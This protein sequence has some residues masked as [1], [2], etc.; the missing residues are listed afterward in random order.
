ME[1]CLWPSAVAP[2][3]SQSTEKVGIVHKWKNYHKGKS[4]L[5]RLTEITSFFTSKNQYFILFSRIRLFLSFSLLQTTK[6]NLKWPTTLQQ[7]WTNW[8]APTL[9][10]FVNAKT[11]LDKFLGAKIL[12]TTWTL[13]SKCSRRM[14]TKKFDWHKTWQWE[15]QT[16]ISLFD[17]GISW[18]LR[19][20]TVVARKIYPCSNETTSK[21][22][23]GAAQNYKRSW[24]CFATMWRS[25]RHHMFRCDSLEEERTMKKNSESV[26]VNYKVYEF[27][28][29]LDVMNSFIDKIIAKYPLC[30][31]S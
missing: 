8:L 21:R 5:I 31:V 30:N 24:L 1:I 14:K 19:S 10:T 28:Y 2:S 29:L 4:C 9:W 18:L 13:N 23:G 22:H 20:A 17:R 25:R 7:L 26:Y 16:L 12:S 6:L 27:I 3:H 11:Y 15:K